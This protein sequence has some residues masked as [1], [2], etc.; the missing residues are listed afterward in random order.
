MIWR[1]VDWVGKQIHE[2]WTPLWQVRTGVLCAF[3]SLVLVVYGV[4]TKEPLLIYQMSAFALVLAGVG[5]IITA[6]LAVEETDEADNI[7]E[8]V[9]IEKKK[10]GKKK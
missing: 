8:L 9:A 10:K 5:L 4:R 3:A 6:V 1:P 7:D 2:H